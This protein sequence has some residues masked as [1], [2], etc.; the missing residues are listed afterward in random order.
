[1]LFSYSSPRSSAL[2]WEKHIALSTQY[3]SGLPEGQIESPWLNLFTG[4][5]SFFI[6]GVELTMNPSCSIFI[7]MNSATM[8]GN[9]QVS[10]LCLCPKNRWGPPLLLPL[11]YKV[12]VYRVG[13]CRQK[14]IPRKTNLHGTNRFDPAEFRLFCGIE[15]SWNSVLNYSA[16][17]K[18]ARNSVL[19]N[20]NRSKLSEFRSELSAE[21][22]TTWNSFPWNK[23]RSKLSEFRSKAFFQTKIRCNY[24]WGSRNF[25]KTHFFSCNSIPF[26]VSE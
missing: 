6:A 26:R 1:M 16:E 21:E 4:V 23:N 22:K 19:W 12:Q 24:V 10:H 8:Y 2:P 11:L 3:Q 5:S 18:N 14:I 7:T 20:K 15:N 17:E 9:R 25:C 13:N